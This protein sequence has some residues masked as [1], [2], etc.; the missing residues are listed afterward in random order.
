MQQIIDPGCNASDPGSNCIN[1]AA[2]VGW[3]LLA[4]SICAFVNVLTSTC[5]ININNFFAVFKVAYVLII[6]LVNIGFGSS[7]GGQCTKITWQAPAG[8]HSAGFGDVVAGLL[9]A[10]YAYTGSSFFSIG[11]EGGKEAYKWSL[12]VTNSLSMY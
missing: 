4:M 12:Q 8:G 5:T 10:T 1:R 3:A 11:V 9:Y 2:M 7:Y 6:S